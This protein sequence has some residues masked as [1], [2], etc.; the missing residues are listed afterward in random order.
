M[1]PETVEKWRLAWVG[2]ILQDSIASLSI[3][4]ISLII[5]PSAYLSLNHSKPAFEIFHLSFFLPHFLVAV[6]RSSNLRA[7]GSY[8]EGTTVD[9]IHCEWVETGQIFLT[10]K[11]CQCPQWRAWSWHDL[12][13]VVGAVVRLNR[14]LIPESCLSKATGG[15]GR[16]EEGREL[17]WD[18]VNKTH[19]CQLC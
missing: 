11:T 19:Q 4:K 14:I 7:K 16:C 17:K 10:A 12:L 13:N 3:S 8:F 2:I 15:E 9:C 18:I 5:S 1:L 6:K